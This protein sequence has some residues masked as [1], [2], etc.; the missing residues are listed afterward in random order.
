MKVS[1]PYTLPTTTSKTEP[2][3]F[4]FEDDE[5]AYINPWLPTH[6]YYH[7]RLDS[8]YTIYRDL[9]NPSVFYVDICGKK[10][11]G[12]KSYFWK[13]SSL[14]ELREII[15]LISTPVRE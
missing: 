4:N 3:I 8:G 5:V 14:S 1:I 11:P 7:E 15:G 12:N 9:K 6:L 13:A 2:E 10:Y